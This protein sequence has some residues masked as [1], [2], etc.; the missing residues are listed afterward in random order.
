MVYLCI[1]Q[2]FPY[3]R[4]SEIFT[5]LYGCSPAKATLMKSIADCA[6]NLEEYE[7]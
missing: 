4:A 6:T 3:E 2:L 1:Y 7:N 5:D